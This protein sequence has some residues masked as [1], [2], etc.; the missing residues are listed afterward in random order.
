[1]KMN[2]AC[3]A[4]ECSHERELESMA[5]RNSINSDSLKVPAN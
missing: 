2:S 3:R 1:M 5:R 4:A